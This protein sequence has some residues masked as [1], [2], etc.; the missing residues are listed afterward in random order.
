MRPATALLLLL[1]SHSQPLSEARSVS[2]DILLEL[3]EARLDE[4]LSSLE[5]DGPRLARKQVEAVRGFGS[6]P[7]MV[8]EALKEPRRPPQ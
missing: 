5:K 2:G 6:V 1:F 3:L 8:G 7:G 4:G